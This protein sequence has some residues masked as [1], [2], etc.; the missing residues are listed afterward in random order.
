MTST[1]MAGAPHATAPIE[2]RAW[3]SLALVSAA[4]CVII[5]DL[6]AAN[7][8]F[9]FIERSFPSTPRTTLAWVSSGYAIASAALLMV[10]GRMSDRHGRRTVFLA[11]V[12]LF[13]VVS[14]ASA[15]APNPA[16]LIAARIVQGGGSAM[17]TSTAVALLLPDF[18]A[19]KRGLALGI[20]GTTSSAGAAA[21][22]T[23]GA[24]AIEALD[25]RLVFLL[26]I[27]IGLVTLL[28]GRRLLREPAR[29]EHAGGIDLVGTVLGTAATALL[30]LGILQ[31][32]GWGWATPAVA[33]ALAASVV[34]AGLFVVRCARAAAPLVDLR[35][36]RHGPF[37][38][39]NLSQAGTQLAIMAWFFTTPLFLINVWHYSALAG[40][41]AVA[42]GMVVSF[43]S[44][45][46][47]QYSDRHGYR[48][49]LFVGGLV[50]AAGMAVWVVGVGAEANFWTAYLAGLVLFGLGAGM[51]GIVVTNA[52]LAGLPD[53]EL[54]AANAVF[55][56]IRKLVGAIGVA[57]AVALLGSRSTDSVDAFRKVWIMIAVGYLLSS[58]AII[59]YRQVTRR[60]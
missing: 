14:L 27:P 7:V 48:T 23:L 50:A 35:L 8:A 32:P 9:P 2:R 31:G 41:G 22:P 33:G 6:M 52:A 30:T 26:N 40:G 47:G 38:L 54:A 1:T 15:A 56:T 20:W 42:I 45:P 37:A 13:S 12:A 17:I 59:P 4:T 10:A 53:G 46:V 21:G 55:Q 11:G 36:F 60:R 34:L 16:V 3:L 24:V 5:L 39:A 43:V 49:V 19:T 51:V 28:L 29:P 25:W 57:I 18:P 44:V 58:L